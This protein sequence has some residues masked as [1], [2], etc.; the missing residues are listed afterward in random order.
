MWPAAGG[1]DLGVDLGTANTLVHVN[2]RGIVVN[3]PTVVALDSET[4]EVRAVGAEARAMIGKTPAN[5]RTVQPLKDGVIGDFDAAVKMLASYFRKAHSHTFGRVA[6]RPRVVVTV[7]RGVTEIEVRAA[8]DAML[9]ANAREAYVVEEPMAAA[10]GAGLPITEPLGSMIVDIGSGTTEVCVISLGGIVVSRTI[11]VAGDAIDAAIASFARSEYH[12]LI[13]ERMAE[14]VKL[15][16]GSAYP[17]DREITVAL[18]G[19]D[20]RTGLPKTVELSSV[21]L[22][23]GIAGPVDAIVAA[24]REVLDETPPEL[25]ADI[26]EHGIQLAGGG[27]LLRG[28]DRRLAA[29]TRIPVRVAEDPLSCVARGAGA[30]AEELSNPQY[31]SLLAGAQS[32]RRIQQ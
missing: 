4:S 27:A 20:L 30:L 10:I 31:R 22:R 26:L 23:A 18:R 16:A 19:R 29:E 32:A 13:G 12:L 7:P 6:P 28:L 14:K 5:I 21:E 11:P 2:G 25:L 3:E 1:A 8:R 17:L 24:V 15:A 9:A